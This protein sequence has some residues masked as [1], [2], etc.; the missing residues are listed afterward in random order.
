MGYVTDHLRERYERVI[1]ANHEGATRTRAKEIAER[2]L[3]WSQDPEGKQ[4]LTTPKAIYEAFRSVFDENTILS[5]AVDSSDKNARL[6]VYKSELA[7]AVEAAA[8]K[9]ARHEVSEG[10]I[11]D[12][13]LES[14]MVAEIK[15]VY[16]AMLKALSEYRH[17]FYESIEA[18]SKGYGL[19]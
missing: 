10:K 1:G 15:L 6:A 19:Q 9:L 17:A 3:H 7:G 11:A 8:V 12:D 18:R 13:K 5:L 14:A 4:N 2:F 16:P